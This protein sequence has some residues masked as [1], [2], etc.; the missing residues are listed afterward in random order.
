ML[1]ALK[2]WNFVDSTLSL[3]LG[4]WLFGWALG[5]LRRTLGRVTA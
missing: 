1:I 4:V 3:A 5:H 2:G